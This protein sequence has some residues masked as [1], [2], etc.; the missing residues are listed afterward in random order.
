MEDSGK[1]VLGGIV[2]ALDKGRMFLRDKIRSHVLVYRGLLLCTMAAASYFSEV[3]LLVIMCCVLWSL[4]GLFVRYVIFG[5]KVGARDES[6]FRQ[7]LI[8]SNALVYI[9]RGFRGFDYTNP[10]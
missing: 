10:T 5:G 9:W 8:A 4:P 3:C 2:L 6:S 7:L 1:G